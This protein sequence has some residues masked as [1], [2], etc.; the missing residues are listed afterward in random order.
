MVGLKFITRFVSVLPPTIQNCGN[1]RGVVR[2]LCYYHC[3]LALVHISHFSFFCVYVFVVVML[4]RTVLLA[5]IGFMPTEGVGAI[6]SIDSPAEERRRLAVLSREWVCSVCKV[7]NK[8]ILVPMKEGQSQDEAMAEAAD[9]VS[10]MAF[11]V[12][13]M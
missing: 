6:G 12:I 7:A 4:V 2:N 9:I 10:Q 13:V 11:K 1:L 8:D 3:C 5:L